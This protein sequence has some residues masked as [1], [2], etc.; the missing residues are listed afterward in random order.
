M[1]ETPAEISAPRH[2]TPRVSVPAGSVGIA[3]RQTG[4]YPFASP[5]GWQ[6]LGQTPLALWDPQAE[7]PAVFAPGDVVHFVA[8]EERRA[9]VPPLPIAVSRRPVFEVIEAGALT[10]V[11]DLGRTGYAHLGVGPSGA[12]DAQAA[13][14]ANSLVSNSRDAAVME[15]TLQGP[16]LRALTSTTLAVTGADFGCSVDGAPLPRGISWF[17]RAGST[18][19]FSGA[20]GG[21]RAYVAL[22]GGLDVPRVLGSRSTSAYGGFGGYGGRPLHAGDVLG[23]AEPPLEPSSLAGR[24]GAEPQSVEPGGRY[25]VRY[26]PFDGPQFA[27]E[28]GRQ[29]LERGEWVVSEHSDRM[30][31]RLTGADP[32]ARVGGELASFPVVQGTIQLPPDGQ[33]IVLGPDH[34]TTGGYPVLGVVAARDRSI[35]AQAAPGTRLRFTPITREEARVLART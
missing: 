7:Q 10:T 13:L 9:E 22:A 25:E 33:P 16:V 28:S 31:L 35:L 29:G 12:F 5:G 27:G 11:Q 3:A 20:A 17:V 23:V 21:V 26:V 30:G 24:I 2:A 1:Y 18:I 8:S 19:R 14:R 15:I 32:I 6:I 4:V 34:Q